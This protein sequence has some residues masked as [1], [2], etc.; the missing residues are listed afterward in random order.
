MAVSGIR[1]AKSDSRDYE[2]HSFHAGD[3]YSDPIKFIEYFVAFLSREFGGERYYK[4]QDLKKLRDATPPLS[5]DQ[6][7]G[8]QD[9]IDAFRFSVNDRSGQVDL[10]G[11]YLDFS[12]AEYSFDDPID[13]DAPD[14]ES[15]NNDQIPANQV[16]AEQAYVV[17]AM[18]RANEDMANN[19]VEIF[20]PAE[21]MAMWYAAC[22]H[23]KLHVANEAYVLRN[24]DPQMIQKAEEKFQAYLNDPETRL[25]ESVEQIFSA[26]S[27]GFLRTRLND[28]SATP[29]DL[30]ADLG[31]PESQTD[32]LSFAK[33][34]AQRLNRVKVTIEGNALPQHWQ[35]PQ[36]NDA[37][38]SNVTADAQEKA[39]EFDM[40]LRQDP[41]VSSE[42]MTVPADGLRDLTNLISDL[43]SAGYTDLA[44]DFKSLGRYYL[45]TFRNVSENRPEQFQTQWQEIMVGALDQI[46]FDAMEKAF[47]DVPGE[48]RNYGFDQDEK[49]PGGEN[50][51]VRYDGQP[52]HAD[53]D[54]GV[55]LEGDFS[56]ASRSKER[57]EA[58]DT[59]LLEGPSSDRYLE[60]PE[61]GDDSP[62]DDHKNGGPNNDSPRPPG[63]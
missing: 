50:L 63:Y 4:S 27:N 21:D 53:E 42:N 17:M 26:P 32:L 56:E 20:G 31:L 14:T 51:P 28:I 36:G 25:S 15:G 6:K 52:R 9:L 22:R 44:Q 48:R 62:E 3:Y 8:V 16:S 55:T 29:Q 12:K 11:R 30:A 59:K 47:E 60:G 24:V 10:Y 39:R 54:E 33:T 18:A 45:D 13:T 58:Q 7:E 5:M 37:G 40:A 2:P 57:P 1:A 23:A 43:E 38:G 35:T 19:G 34:I 41:A 49:S 46:D 61:D